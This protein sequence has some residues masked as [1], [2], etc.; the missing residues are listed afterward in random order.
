M[1]VEPGLF[2]WTSVDCE[3]HFRLRRRHVVGLVLPLY[4]PW[5]WRIETLHFES[6]FDD[7]VD[8]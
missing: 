3:F 5:D 6:D 4:Q 2:V 7:D 1:K 8:D